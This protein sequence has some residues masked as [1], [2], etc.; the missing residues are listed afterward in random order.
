MGKEQSHFHSGGWAWRPDSKITKALSEGSSKIRIAQRKRATELF[1]NQEH[2]HMT[3][4]NKIFNEKE[5]AKMAKADSKKAAA[6][7]KAEAK[8][9]G[10]K[11]V[12]KKV[13][14]KKVTA[15]KST[16]GTVKTKSKDSNLLP[17]KRI[18]PA[19]MDAKLA[20]KKL[21]AAGIKGHDPKARWEFT[22]AGAEAAL[23]ILKAG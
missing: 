11:K 12:V 10:K 15:K 22:E 23:K 4:E 8:K 13:T 2:S 3:L 5:D 6:K 21:R 1:A 9:T 18:L 7:K 19:D 14:V 20:R 17:L 16:T